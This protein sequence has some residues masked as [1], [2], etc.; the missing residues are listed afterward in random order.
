MKRME[1]PLFG[2]TG[3]YFGQ[4]LDPEQTINLFA[5]QID[6]TSTKAYITIPGSMPLYTPPS[7]ENTR[8]LYNNSDNLFAVFSNQ[9]VRFDTS[10]SP[11][12]LT[13]TLS[14]TE[15]L[16]RIEEN[17]SRQIMFVD[18]LDGYIY[19][20]AM[21]TF[22]QI[23]DSDFTSLNNPIDV[24]FFDGHM[25][26]GFGSSNTFAISNVNNAANWNA[27][28]RFE[29]TSSGDE[30]VRGIRTLGSR[31]FV[32]GRYVTERWYNTGSSNPSLFARDNNLILQYGCAA[33]GS[34]AKGNL[35]SGER[36]LVWLA[37][38]KGGTISVR[39]TSGGISEAISTPAIEFR[40]AQ[41][42]D[43]SSARAYM[44]TIDGHSFYLINFTDERVNESGQSV[45]NITF[46]YDFD[47]K[48]WHEQQMAQGE[49]YFSNSHA[50]FNRQHILGHYN[51]AKL[52]ELSSAY[53]FNDDE[54]IHCSRTTS[55]FSVPTNERVRIDRLILE[56]RQ[57]TGIVGEGQTQDVNPKIIL[58]Q[59]LNGGY[60]FAQQLPKEIGAVG[61]TN[62]LT[63]WDDIGISDKWCFR[64]ETRN[65]VKTIL[66]NLSAQ[67]SVEGYP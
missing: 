46:V 49:G 47:S 36:I 11:L 17:N 42:S 13:P 6:G 57:G 60:T 14:T 62:W 38:E 26:V 33:T 25:F 64:L 35:T 12:N 52:S 63:Y 53:A 44:Y 55:L 27:L 39:M 3:G 40:I 41:L 56:M 51:E 8:A 9:V 58:S 23:G 50:F 10:L 59:S 54:I 34:I 48:L 65:K 24:D 31:V 2:H 4:Q 28:N 43:I 37:E 16:V 22:T 20:T 18:G 19:D 30:R 15:G 1:I 21:A 7:G 32:F 67:L 61:Q 5:A 29:I 66:L 45:N